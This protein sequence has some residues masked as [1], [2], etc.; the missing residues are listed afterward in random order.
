MNLETVFYNKRKLSNDYIGL[1]MGPRKL[2]F[3]ATSVSI[4]ADVDIDQVKKL[5]PHGGMIGVGNSQLE[6]IFG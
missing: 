4:K 1:D 5:R 2:Y 6:K 3:L